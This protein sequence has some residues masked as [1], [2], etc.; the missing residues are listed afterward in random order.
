MANFSPVV[1][2]IIVIILLKTFVVG[3]LSNSFVQIKKKTLCKRIEWCVTRTNQIAALGCVSRT[4]RGS[5]SYAQRMKL[6][7]RMTLT[8]NFGLI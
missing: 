5:R 4:N 6:T 1:Y 2:K 3:F 8:V 7:Q